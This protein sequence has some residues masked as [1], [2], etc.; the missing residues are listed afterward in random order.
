MKSSHCPKYERKNKKKS[1]RNFLTI[2]HWYLKQWFAR[3][4]TKF[5]GT[6]FLLILSQPSAEKY[7]C[8][9]LTTG[10][11]IRKNSWR[12]SERKTQPTSRSYFVTT[13][14][15]YFFWFYRYK[16]RGSRILSRKIKG[17]W[18]IVSVRFVLTMKGRFYFYP[19]V[20]SFVVKFV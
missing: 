14:F 16:L 1:A 2:V 6:P 18:Q 10:K 9:Y 8:K 12:D 20:T 13:K 3:I 11:F 15:Q 19:V 5:W 17:L 7:Y 4:S